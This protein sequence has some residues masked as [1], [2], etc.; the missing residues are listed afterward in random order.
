[1][2]LTDNMEVTSSDVEV[3]ENT[4]VNDNTDVRDKIEAIPHCVLGIDFGTTNSCA[5]YYN[6]HKGVVDVIVNPQ[7]NSVSPSCVSFS[8]DQE[9]LF[10]EPAYSTTGN[11]VSNFKRLLGIDWADYSSNTQLHTF[12]KNKAIDIVPE[13]HGT[14]LAV[15]VDTH[16][17][18]IEQVI[19]LYLAWLLRLARDNTGIHFTEV[20]ATVPAYFN[21]QQR[22]TLKTILTELNVNLL[23]IINEP[24]AAALAYGVKALAGRQSH[25]TVVVI[26]CGGGT[27]DLS[28]VSLDYESNV[29]EVKSVLGDNFLGG[30]D[31]TW[32]L[33]DYVYQKHFLNGTRNPE[34]RAVLTSK[35]RNRLRKEC[36]RVKCALSYSSSDKIVI[37][38]FTA[39]THLF[40]TIT[41][42]QFYQSNTEW[43]KK[44][45]DYIQEI[46]FG[47]T[48]SID[49]VVLVGGTTRIPR[50]T[51]IC[52]QVLGP[53]IAICNNLDPDQ[54]VSIGAAIQGQLLNNSHKN[55]NDNN[56][57]QSQ[58]DS[59]ILLD[60]LYMTLGVETAGG[61]MTPIVSKNTHLPTSK[62]QVFTNTDEE[63]D[64]ITVNVYQGERRFVQDNYFLGSFTLRQLDPTLKSGEMKIRITFNIDVNGIINVTAT[65]AKTGQTQSIAI[66][67]SSTEN[68]SSTDK[69]SSTENNSST[70][71]LDTVFA[72]NHRANQLLAKMELQN[73]LQT[74]EKLFHGAKPLL[75][76]ECSQNILEKV[77]VVFA[78]IKTVIQ[79]YENYTSSQL[80]QTRLQFEQEFHKLLTESEEN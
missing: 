54:T 11:C 19:R 75:L 21:E 43:F 69:N 12:F 63:T 10:G 7:G 15:K 47:Y 41:R 80:T 59:V 14:K 56:N 51:E 8:D 55:N 3:I 20:V 18:P 13:S 35:Q 26:D 29:Y 70:D 39:E 44:L 32:G 25:E 50:V 53:N 5:S 73:T 4:V 67:K 23:R 61:F 68:N 24:T 17:I 45:H 48:E 49:K 62:T 42:N 66:N 60:V 30:E 36:E 77:N 46:T 31:L 40:A 57:T 9:V 78:R 74:L 52:R 6:H 27:T 38:N 64:S 65:D 58:D 79:D 2:D 34:S 72:D 76:E 22:T 16:K 1:M 33:V 71:I 28:I 37:E